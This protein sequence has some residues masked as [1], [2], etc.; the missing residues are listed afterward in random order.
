[1]SSTP[2]KKQ[3]GLRPFL[4]G[5]ET[6]W[7]ILPNSTSMMHGFEDET[8]A[9]NGSDRIG[10]GSTRCGLGLPE[11]RPGPERVE[12]DPPADIRSPPGPATIYG[13]T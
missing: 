8:R 11:P 10:S 3:N 6:P 2:S 7:S 12:P 13:N 5:L 4:R 9:P 1:M